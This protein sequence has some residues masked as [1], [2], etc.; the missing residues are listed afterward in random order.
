MAAAAVT[1][2]ITRARSGLSILNQ[3]LGKWH[4]RSRKK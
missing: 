3:V 1:A 2:V 4:S